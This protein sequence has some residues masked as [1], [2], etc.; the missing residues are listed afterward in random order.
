MQSQNDI[1]LQLHHIN[2]GVFAPSALELHSEVFYFSSFC[3]ICFISV[4]MWSLNMTF[5]QTLITRFF[6]TVI[7]TLIL[8][9][10]LVSKSTFERQRSFHV[11]KDSPQ[12]W[13]K[14]GWCGSWTLVLGHTLFLGLSQ[15][16]VSTATP[17]ELSWHVSLL[18]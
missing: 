7:R 10:V 9:L 1:L 11:R 5:L 15:S 12:W 17:P 6:V 3:G 8:L 16:K 18:P 13:F 2:G 4:T 14:F